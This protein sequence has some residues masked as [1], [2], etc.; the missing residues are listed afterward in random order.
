LG[1]LICS[2]CNH[3]AGK[4]KPPQTTFW[5]SLICPDC[6]NSKFFQL[7]KLPSGVEESTITGQDGVTSDSLTNREPKAQSSSEDIKTNLLLLTCATCGHQFSKR[8]KE[9]PKCGWQQ[10]AICQICHQHIPYDSSSC[11]E[12]GDPKPF[13]KKES[14]MPYVGKKNITTDTSSFDAQKTQI[15]KKI[16][17]T[18][19]VSKP[20]ENKLHKNTSKTSLWSWKTLIISLI[21]SFFLNIFLSAATGTKPSKNIIW[22]VIWIYQSIEAWKYWRW[23]ALLPYPLSLLVTYLLIVIVAAIPGTEELFW[24]NIIVMGTC[25]I[26]GLV[27]FYQLLQNSRKTSYSL[28]GTD[29]N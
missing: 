25:N 16:S 28:M 14:H 7:P 24:V 8:A 1:Y 20:I 9:C 18:N 3:V 4:D 15:H 2:K 27:I 5:G 6:G 10:Q 29:Q 11:P 19:A 21:I 12:C 23:K 13:G 22:T 26:G 17:E